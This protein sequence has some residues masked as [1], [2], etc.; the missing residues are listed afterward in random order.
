M[1]RWVVAA[2]LVGAG[3]GV[4]FSCFRSDSL[5][6]PV[7]PAARPAAQA[8]LGTGEPRQKPAPFELDTFEPLLARPSLAEVRELVESEDF[9]E[10]A[11]R[12]E[13]QLAKLGPNASE[14]PR[15]A[16]LLGGFWERAGRLREAER[17]YQASSALDWPLSG[18][19]AVASARLLVALD[20]PQAALERL[21]LPAASEALFRQ[22]LQVESR[23]L[24]K[25]G[26]LEQAIERQRKLLG[27]RGASPEQELE[28]A[29]LLLRSLDSMAPALSDELRASRKKEAFALA[30]RVRLR[31]ATEP[32]VASALSLE[33]RALSAL[34]AERSRYEPESPEDLLVAVGSLVDS[35]RFAEALTQVD[36][37][38]SRLAAAERYGRVGC[39][40]ALLEAKA[41]AGQS[42]WSEATDALS[43]PLRFCKGDDEF[44]ARLYFLSG[45][46]GAAA[47]RHAFATRIYQRI[48]DELPSHSFADD[49]RLRAARS[50]RKLGADARFAELLERIVDDYPKGDMTLDGVFELALSRIEKADWNGAAVALERGITLATW[51]DPTRAPEVA[52]RERYFRARAWIATGEE[53]PGFAEYEKLIF[54]RPLSYYMLH[55]YTRL[56]AVAPERAKQALERGLERAQQT[57]LSF[58]HRPEYQ[59]PGF[60]RALQLLALGELGLAQAELL[61]LGLGGPEAGPGALWGVALLYHR[62]GFSSLAH[63][64]MRSLKADWL[65]HWPAGEWEKAWQVAFPRPFERIVQRESAKSG[66]PEYLVY[67]IM[68]E[69]S[70]FDETA[71][72]TANA[73]GLMQLILPTARTVATP[74]GLSATPE[75]LFRPAVNVRLGSILLGQLGREFARNPLL[76]VPAYNAGPGRPRR[77]L[78]EFPVADFDVWVELIPFHET[79]MYTKR[80]LASRATYAWLYQREQAEHAFLLPEKP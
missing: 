72:S 79:R 25:K 14:R 53:A 29:G 56:S 19:A 27:A 39:D 10:A 18:Y 38:K 44:K 52:G 36:T 76:A 77:W 12:L 2:A 5:R 13:Q 43:D 64:M 42:K 26:E 24:A 1:K 16:Y 48:E 33:Q 59:T 58:E 23:A 61:E 80:V 4:G 41:F 71:V 78:R 49:A 7:E 73:Y 28:L 54:E 74:L 66:V 50:F 32:L 67:A 63:R 11:T 65:E 46:Y 57:A 3:L 31:A 8:P 70:A 30:R 62:A 55:A 47:G 69:E 51:A 17:Q 15:Y 21:Q 20:E 75:A 34:G 22:V 35:R 40:A 9:G 6:G 37:L 45:R 60:S 68:R